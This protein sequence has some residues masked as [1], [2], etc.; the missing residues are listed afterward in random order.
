MKILR[1]SFFNICWKK[2]D[3]FF[4]CC[5][6]EG[7]YPYISNVSSHRRFTHFPARTTLYICIMRARDRRSVLVRDARATPSE[8][9]WRSSVLA[10]RDAESV[11][12]IQSY[13]LGPLCRT[14]NARSASVRGCVSAYPRDDGPR[15]P[16]SATETPSRRDG[17]ETETHGGMDTSAW[18]GCAVR[19][20]W[21]SRQ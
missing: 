20:H 14:A 10:V 2:V 21:G 13:C 17:K 8:R 18:E 1:L 12:E 16:P 7:S 6:I 5:E 9:W 3:W 4:G 19:F 11:G 15:F